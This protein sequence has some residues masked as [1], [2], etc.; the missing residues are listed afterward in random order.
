MTSDREPFDRDSFD[1]ERFDR[2]PDREPADRPPPGRAPGDANDPLA[3][4]G[5]GEW[6]EQIIDGTAL[7][8]LPES[9][10]DNPD[11]GGAGSPLVGAI[12]S[13]EHY[14][15]PEPPPF[16]YISPP[17]VLGA[18]GT[19]AGVT[20][21]LWPGSLASF[22]AVSTALVMLLGVALLIAG[23]VT[24][25]SRLRNPDPEEDDDDI[26]PDNGAVV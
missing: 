20:L 25:V 4:T 10:P 11:R 9:H 18:L 1:R 6:W 21:I 3:R 13:D 16:P 24:L 12:E 5:D 14:V 19:L 17:T 26:D 23:V 15:P 22:L 2:Q 7:P 8:D